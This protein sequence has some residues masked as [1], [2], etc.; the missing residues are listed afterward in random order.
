[1]LD[2]KTVEGEQQNKLLTDSDIESFAINGFVVKR[3]ALDFDLI[4]RKSV[5]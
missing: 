5:V 3:G 1:M 4:D 2:A